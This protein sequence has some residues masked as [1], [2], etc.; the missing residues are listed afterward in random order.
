LHVYNFD[1]NVNAWLTP[2]AVIPHPDGTPDDRLGSQFAA[3]RQAVD[4][5]GKHILAGTPLGGM[6]GFFGEEGGG[7]TF[8]FQRSNSGWQLSGRLLSPILLDERLWFGQSTTFLGDGFVGVAEV[9]CC[10]L[11]GGKLFLYEIDD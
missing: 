2:Q 9:D 1:A 4:T 10:G 6:G 3:G 5:D 11:G 7:D 8:L